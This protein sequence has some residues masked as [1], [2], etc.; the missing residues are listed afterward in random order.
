MSKPNKVS[1]EKFDWTKKS[2]KRLPDGT[3]DPAQCMGFLNEAFDPY[4]RVKAEYQDT[5]EVQMEV[6]DFL[7][8]LAKSL[9]WISEEYDNDPKVTEA[10]M[11][12][13]AEWLFVVRIAWLNKTKIEE[14]HPREI[15]YPT[16]FFPYLR[17]VAIYEGGE[18]DGL[19]LL[20]KLSKTLEEKWY[21]KSKK[22]IKKWAEY[23]RVVRACRNAGIMLS[24][25]VPMDKVSHDRRWYELHLDVD[26]KRILGTTGETPSPDRKSVV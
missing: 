7:K 26:S 24:K 1:G 17:E 15:F 23:D 21:D 10:D 2:V 11:V 14:V 4:R 8:T 12:E 3:F 6:S 16:P 9:V 13:Y 22:Q 19:T 25:S 18:V 5:T 20:P